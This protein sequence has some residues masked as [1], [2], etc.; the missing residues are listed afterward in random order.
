MRLGNHERPVPRPINLGNPNEMTVAELS[1]MVLAL[2]GSRSQ[3][4][5]KP[6]PVDDPKRRRPHIG[7]A[8]EI[9]GWEPKTPLAKGLAQTVEWFAGDPSAVTGRTTARKIN[10]RA[11]RANTADA[12]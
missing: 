2:T 4:V 8:K 10:V 6:L 3:V 9:L 1:E 11:S 12:A 5:R 7:A